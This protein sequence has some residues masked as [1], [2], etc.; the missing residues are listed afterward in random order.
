MKLTPKTLENVSLS[1]GLAP[2]NELISGIWA[3]SLDQGVST[4]GSFLLSLGIINRIS[5]SHHLAGKYLSA[6][7]NMPVNQIVIFIHNHLLKWA[8]RIVP[9]PGSL[10]LSSFL[11]SS[12][13]SCFFNSLLC[14]SF[15]Y[16]FLCCCLGHGD[17]GY[18]LGCDLGCDLG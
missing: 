8:R 9:G 2:A 18:G 15:S 16:C 7:F 6:S 14:W 5:S 13:W 17:L 11:G 4:H 3:E 10:L 1:L 12:F